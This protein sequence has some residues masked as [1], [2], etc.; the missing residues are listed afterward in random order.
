[1]RCVNVQGAEP[2][3]FPWVI[4]KLL[5]FRVLVSRVAPVFQ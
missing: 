2:S 5:I 3:L 4:V 1:M